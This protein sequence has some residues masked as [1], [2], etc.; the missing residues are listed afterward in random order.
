MDADNDLIIA[1]LLYN[2]YL[3]NQIKLIE[4]LE[5]FNFDVCSLI[6]SYQEDETHTYSARKLNLLH[7]LEEKGHLHKRV[8]GL[9]LANEF[10]NLQCIQRELYLDSE[11]FFDDYQISI[12]TLAWYYDALDDQMQ[13]FLPDG[14]TPM[15]GASRVYYKMLSLIKDLFVRYY[16]SDDDSKIYQLWL[17][18][19]LCVCSN[20]N[21]NYKEIKSNKIPKSDEVHP[22]LREYA[23]RL[24]DTWSDR[25]LEE[26]LNWYLR[27][28]VSY[29]IGNCK[30]QI[31]IFVIKDQQISFYSTTFE[32]G[33]CQIEYIKNPTIKL[34]RYY[35]KKLVYILREKFIRGRYNCVTNRIKMFNDG[36]QELGLEGIC[37]KNDIVY[38]KVKPGEE[39]EKYLHNYLKS[40]KIK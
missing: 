5:E 23:E 12:N 4:I 22:I 31:N 40:H 21:T 13:C 36:I 8:K 34:N 25:I 32:P 35:S 10:S 15:E 17:S 20:E 9:I 26:G 14:K 16:Q 30:D 2:G 38:K 29:Q 27:D 18:N 11:K 39:E 6:C 37:K 1:G 28:L 33:D 19:H 7:S 24:E 3:Y